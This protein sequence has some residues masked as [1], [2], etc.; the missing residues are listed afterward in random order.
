MAFEPLDL[1]RHAVKSSRQS[2]FKPVGAVG[3][4]MRGDRRLD[5]GGSRHPLLGCVIGEPEGDVRREPNRMVSAHWGS[6]TH[7]VGGIEC[8]LARVRA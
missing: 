5:D 4:E 3:C 6:Q 2:G 8:G 7:S 1:P